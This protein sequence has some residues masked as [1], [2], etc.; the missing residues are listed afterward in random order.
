MDPAGG[1]QAIAAAV[2]HVIVPMNDVT[3]HKRYVSGSR[4]GYRGFEKD[5]LAPVHW[6]VVGM[7]PK[8]TAI[9]LADVI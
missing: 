2:A 3:D 4:T 1:K 7:K 9:S 8:K 6:S 5:Q